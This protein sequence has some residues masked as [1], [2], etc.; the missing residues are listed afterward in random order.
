MTNLIKIDFKE[1][2]EDRDFMKR[3]DS[4]L[5]D[6]AQIIKFTNQNKKERNNEKN[7][8]IQFSHYQRKKPK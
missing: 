4:L 1:I 3:M 7:K 8:I 6:E 2:R 5:M